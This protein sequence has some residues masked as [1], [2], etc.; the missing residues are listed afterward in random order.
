MF[1]LQG[2]SALSEF[3]LHSLL[4]LCQKEQSE[5]E[6]IHAYE[7]FF[8]QA[9]TM[10]QG[11]EF[12]K[13][14]SVLS[15]NEATKPQE[16]G[17]WVVPRLGTQ[18]PW[19]SKATEILQR[20]Q[21]RA[22]NRIEKGIVY[23]LFLKNGAIGT[24]QTLTQTVLAHL[25]DKMTQSLL[26]EPPLHALFKGAPQKPLVRVPV[27]QHG[28][29]AL[30]TA[31][32]RLGLALSQVEM[33][34]IEAFFQD[35]KRDPSDAEL[36]MFAQANSEHCRHK[37][38]NAHWTIESHEQKDSLFSMIKHTYSNYSQE[39]LSAYEDNAAVFQGRTGTQFFS[40]AKGKY[41]EHLGEWG[42]LIKVE[43]HNHPS[44]IAPYEGA[45]TGIGGEIRDEGACGIG[46]RPKA[47]L[48]G[49]SVSHL[50]I[51]G[52]EHPWETSVGHPSRISSALE[53]MLQA[54]IGG[55][56]F[57]NEFGRPNL[58]GY[59][60]TFEY[61][62]KSTADGVGFGYHKPIMIAG[63]YGA[64]EKHHIHKKPLNPGMKLLVIGGPAMNIGLGGGAASSLSQ[65]SSDAQLDFSSVQRSDPQMQRR[66]QQLINRCIA[67]KEANP[68][69]SFHDVGAGGLSNAIP[70]ILN[71]AKVG[72][73]VELRAIDNLEPGMSPMEIWCNE[74]QERYVLAINQ[75]DLNAF[76]DMA[77]VERCP[78]QVV[79]TL[80][81]ERR[82]TLWDSHFE[83]APIDVPLS[84]LFG[85]IEPLK[86][87]AN[88][89][90]GYSQSYDFNALDLTQSIEH[91]LQLPCVADKSFLI[92]IG[93]RSVSGLVAQDQLVGPRQIPV[94]DCAVTLANFKEFH[95][96]AMAM[97][98]K[99]P[100]ALL[101]PAA[102]AKMAVGEAVTN[103]AGADIAS[104][105]KIKLSANWMAD[106][107]EPLSDALYQA[108]RAIGLELCPD[109]NLTIPVGKDSLSM[110]THWQKGE[111]SYTIK[112]P[113]SLVIS[114]FAQVN[115]VRRTL[116]PQLKSV[117]SDLF[118][119]DLGGGKKRMGASALAT[120][121]NVLG[122]EVPNV[123]DSKRLHDFF[124]MVQHLKDQ[125]LIH[126]YHDRSD[127]GLITTLVEMA[128][129]GHVSL[130]IQ[131]DAYQQNN[132]GL[133][134]ALF[135]EELGAVVQVSEDKIEAFIESV[136]GSGLSSH[137]HWVAKVINE[138]PP[139]LKISSVEHGT[140]TRPLMDLKAL[141]S[142]TSYQM[143]ALRDNPLCA[144]QEYTA[145]I[146]PHAPGLFA[147]V[148]YDF[149]APLSASL[150]SHRPKV[151]ILREQGV[152]GHVEMAGAFVAG[153]FESID[154]TMEDLLTQRVDLADFKGLAVCGGFSFGDVLGAGR[155]WAQSILFNTQLREMFQTYFNRDDTFSLG[156]CNG[157]Q[158]LSALKE[159]IPGADHW[160]EFVTNTS[161]QFESRLSM[162][163]VLPSP[164]VLFE[165]M[166]GTMIPIV[167]AH[168]QGRAAFKNSAQKENLLQQKLVAL[169]YIDNTGNRTQM[170]PYNP[171]GS[172]QG[173]TGFTTTDGKVTIMMPH[174][175]RVFRSVQL[176][177]HPKQWR[178]ATP[179][180]S[181]FKNARKWLN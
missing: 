181:L 167:V 125:E 83:N 96:E 121:H 67:L 114:A 136:K 52:Y 112:S 50:K 27:L 8:V 93:D 157:C 44:A 176:S 166:H 131:L 2:L 23:Q 60:R 116:T 79:G 53:I 17:I 29:E 140:W 97:G 164:S 108:V 123:D 159:L 42:I 128:F 66:C 26:F 95:G 74:A 63:G 133:I 33:D 48:C 41:Q 7:V 151:A 177:W 137:I 72:A 143:Q 75:Q 49:F 91:V 127:G 85:A 28:Q 76:L 113:V 138:T 107:K 124:E 61:Y 102:S 80:H 40:S 38:F 46:G 58:C 171:N 30:Q 139:Q 84:F 158:M 148:P 179:W 90:E 101:N 130:D 110:S 32:Q 12:E 15:L 105:S 51:P 126:A 71:D 16:T 87:S 170:F 77:H 103:L 142:Q 31:N 160:P 129:A 57:N 153:G 168:Q 82:L 145:K 169:R 115:D 11:K 68:I 106:C 21:L 154:V 14:L 62:P 36:M 81:S 55:A 45:A 175:E 22:I 134:E 155:G 70:E 3:R 150:L 118:L 69:Q 144:Q 9:D 89:F 18:S 178:D 78:V 98:E 10:P 47:G 92:H 163:E 161:E 174:P 99:S 173:M 39:I 172:E 122:E 59:F 88:S 111:Q 120:V 109:L 104:I 56:S 135:N 1:V 19:S 147:Q 25:Y 73:R 13:L 65:G 37:I 94:A 100:L 165:G 180:L 162:V 6:R 64:I 43:T 141:W 24:Q 34:Y 132:E 54:P 5:I 119:I 156:V 35:L 152:N 149:E 4:K 146:D 20:C 86:L 117:P